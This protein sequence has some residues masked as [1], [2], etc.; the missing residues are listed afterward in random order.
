[1]AYR[2]EVEAD[3]GDIP[4]PGFAIRRFA[5]RLLIEEPV[6]ELARWLSEQSR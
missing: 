5:R 6:R 2:L 3:T 4:L 1:V